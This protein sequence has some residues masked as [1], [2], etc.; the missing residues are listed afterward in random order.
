MGSFAFH[1][2]SS[3]RAAAAAATASF[4]A[5]LDVDDDGYG[6]QRDSTEYRPD[7]APTAKGQVGGGEDDSEEEID[8]RLYCVCRQLYDDR[9]MLGCEKCVWFAR[10][11]PSFSV[12]GFTCSRGVLAATI[13]STPFAYN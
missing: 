7:A 6:D 11:Y 9:F 5:V 13:G 8:M 12:R 3:G 1:G 10:H 4:G 2:T